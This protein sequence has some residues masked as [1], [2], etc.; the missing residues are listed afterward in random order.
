MNIFGVGIQEA[1][2]IIIIMLI[3]LGPRDMVVTARKVGLFIRKVVRSPFWSQIMET[4]REI[5]DIPT[6]IVR[7]AGIEEDLAEFQRSTRGTPAYLRELNRDLQAVTGGSK[8]VAAPAEKLEVVA[9]AEMLSGGNGDQP[10]QENRIDPRPA[11]PPDGEGNPG[12]Q[13]TE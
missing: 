4:S 9:G 1:L 5:R 7:E 13:T 8:T 3:L 6:K 11:Q 10:E 12:D 2:F